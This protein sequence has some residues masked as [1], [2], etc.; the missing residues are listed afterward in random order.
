MENE[1]KRKKLEKNRVDKIAGGGK[2]N[3]GKNKSHNII[4]RRNGI[5]KKK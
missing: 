1:K 5:M 4:L 2:L 3:N